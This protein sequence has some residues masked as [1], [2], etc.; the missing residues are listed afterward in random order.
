MMLPIGCRV[1]NDAF[2]VKATILWCGLVWKRTFPSPI[3][4]QIARSS[5]YKWRG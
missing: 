4:P 1:L 5:F 2:T 3:Y